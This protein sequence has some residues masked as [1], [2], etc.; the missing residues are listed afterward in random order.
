MAGFLLVK[1]LM[2]QLPFHLDVFYRL[3]FWAP[4]LDPP[5]IRLLFLPQFPFTLFRSLSART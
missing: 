5:S 4:P 1:A 3:C 2:T